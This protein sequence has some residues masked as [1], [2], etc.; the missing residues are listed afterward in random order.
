MVMVGNILLLHV[1]FN[2]NLLLFMVGD[3][4]L[5]SLAQFLDVSFV[6]LLDKDA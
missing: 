6:S 4:A 3:A 1:S 2:G 5:G